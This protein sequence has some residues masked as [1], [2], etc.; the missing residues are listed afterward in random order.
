MPSTADASEA[1]G[2]P[3]GLQHAERLVIEDLKRMFGNE[4]QVS[5]LK[6]TPGRFRGKD[7]W[8]VEGSFWS[9][10]APR[11]FQYAIT[12]DTGELA[13]KRIDR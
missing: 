4:V 10:F 5:S 8:V 9:N 12:S 7:Y 1:A 13:A 3:V 11:N 6:T 2:S